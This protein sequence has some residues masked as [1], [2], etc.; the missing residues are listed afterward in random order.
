MQLFF[1]KNIFLFFWI[2]ATAEI[3]IQL[4]NAGFLQ[5]VF[6][7]LLL[8]LLMAAVILH[9]NPS[10]SR[11]VL[12]AAL[13]FSFAGDVF[14]LFESWHPNWFI[15]GLICFLL[16]HIFYCWYFLKIK[17]SEESQLL[18]SPWI[19]TVVLTY[20]GC[21]IWLLYPKLGQLAIPVII[22]ACV[23]TAMLLCCIHA[24]TSMTI[25]AKKLA[26]IGAVCFV[27]SDSLLAINKFYASF[28]YAGIFIMLTYCFAQYLIVKGFIKD[29]D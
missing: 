8:P 10:G 21:L 4:L 27:I 22:Y 15:A 19:F 9:S 26:I 7:P 1:K 28:T 12:A 11:N 29:N 5:I 3:L 13:F 6:K 2:V 25:E 24:S 18:Q 23:L 16:T 20:T 14:L 17:G